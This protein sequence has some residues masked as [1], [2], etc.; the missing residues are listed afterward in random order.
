MATGRVAV[1]A[2]AADPYQLRGAAEAER[3]AAQTPG[4]HQRWQRC[5][6][7]AGPRQPA[8]RPGSP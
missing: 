6:Y 3:R 2:R 7:A 4:L 8:A 1:A 5:H